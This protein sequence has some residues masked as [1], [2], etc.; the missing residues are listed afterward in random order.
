MRATAGTSTAGVEFTG[1]V[2]GL[3]WVE[4][5][6][7]LDVSRE[8][9]EGGCCG[10]EEE[11]GGREGAEKEGGH[12]GGCNGRCVFNGICVVARDDSVEQEYSNEGRPVR[13]LLA[14]FRKFSFS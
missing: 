3:C 6:G 9:R 1:A 11:C 7:P 12:F 13:I 5:E 4:V 14:T 8:E 2:A 10:C